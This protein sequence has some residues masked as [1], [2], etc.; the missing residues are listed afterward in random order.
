MTH[1]FRIIM[2]SLTTMAVAPL[3]YG[4]EKNMKLDVFSKIKV[5]A[6]VD[7][8]VSV[9]KE[10]KFSMKGSQDDL[11]KIVVMV[12]GDYLIIKKK[13]HSGSMDQVTVSVGVE[14]LTA[15]VINGS[16]NAKIHDVDSKSFE[17]Q[18]NGSGDVVFD[19]QSEALE[20]EINGNG[21]VF[22]SDFNTVSVSAEINGSGDIGLA[23]DCKS[24]RVSI[25]GSGD[26]SGR[27]LKCATVHSRISG[28]GDAV[29]YASESIQVSTSGS[30]DVDVYGNPQSIKNRSSGSSSFVVHNGK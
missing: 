4:A 23:G 3:A 18:I 20:V 16:S 11:D 7:L 5:Y 27:E 2:L 8:D 12:K 13:K 19:G 14:D 29:L 1:I 30:S 9:G 28:S 24:L 25:S 21:D 17:L 22:S 26:F 10:Q 6:P 15:F